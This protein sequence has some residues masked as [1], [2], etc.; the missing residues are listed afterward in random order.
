MEGFVCAMLASIILA[1]KAMRR[2]VGNS[3]LG[4]LGDVLDRAY[5]VS[6]VFDI[7][8]SSSRI[9]CDHTFP[10]NRP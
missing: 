2:K 7:Y 4:M 8:I 5:I 9:M 1:L 6:N 10:L 3:E